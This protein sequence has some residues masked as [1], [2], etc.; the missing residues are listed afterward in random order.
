MD[1]VKRVKLTK[2]SKTWIC[3]PELCNLLSSEMLEI[4]QGSEV[5]Q[6]N[7]Y[8]ISL[9]PH[10]VLLGFFLLK[11]KLIELPKPVLYCQI[12]YSAEKPYTGSKAGSVS[13][14]L[15]FPC[16][17]HETKRQEIPSATPRNAPAW[18]SPNKAELPKLCQPSVNLPR[19]LG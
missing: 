7:I 5:C 19:S 4:P 17:L 1:V 3:K 12:S 8:C 9:I 15:E 13:L 16:Y 14:H 2:H 10:T 11:M 6:E 18:K